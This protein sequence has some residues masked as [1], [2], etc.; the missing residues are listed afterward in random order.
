MLDQAMKWLR[1]R[2][3]EP[4][5]Q[6]SLPMLVISVVAIVYAI[7]RGE[8]SAAIVA[9]GTALYSAIHSAQEG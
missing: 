2:L 9:A 6:R 8:D 5:T 4:S 1:A 7:I 3:A